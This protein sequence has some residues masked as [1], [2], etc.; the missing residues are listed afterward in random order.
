MELVGGL[1]VGEIWYNY[2]LTGRSNGH[3]VC[4]LVKQGCSFDW[5]T[6]GNE[7]EKPA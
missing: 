4:G 2:Y 5:I 3:Q 7:K 1:F 6:G